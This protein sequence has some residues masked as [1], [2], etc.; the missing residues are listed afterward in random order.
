MKLL[1]TGL[2]AAFLAFSS[3][4]GEFTSWSLAMSAAVNFVACWHYYRIWDVR[5]QVYLGQ[6]YAHWTAKVGRAPAEDTALL[7]AE[8][9]HD[10]RVVYIQETIVD[11]LRH[12]DW[13]CTLVL[14]TL[15]LGHLR[16][17]L[18]YVTSGAIPDMK[19]S[20]EWVASLQA[21]MIGFA[22]IWRFYTN[23]ARSVLRPDGKHQSPSVATMVLGWG[24]LA[25]SC[26]LFI[27]IVW[28]LVDGLPD[29]SSA[30]PSHVNADIVC[31]R[32]LVWVWILYP[33]VAITPRLAQWN[34]PGSEYSATWSIVKD[35]AF[36]S[37][38]IT[39]KG[40]LALWL[41]LK[42]GWLSG[43][44]EDALVATGKGALGVST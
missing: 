31:L 15:D 25:V 20:K 43:D 32:L 18:H 41:I 17:Y 28:G 39:S 13:L 42:T 21:I 44:A 36:A 16:T 38:D 19:I 9:E 23:E 5:N 6:K 3:H 30:F 12:S 24:S 33:V 34:T 2:V 4:V 11:G 10:G 35:I 40:G 37:L 27:V 1:G 29:T 22:S 26:A 7:A 14:M 8:K